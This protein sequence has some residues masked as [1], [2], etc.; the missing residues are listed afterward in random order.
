MGRSAARALFGNLIYFIGIYSGFK[1]V[2]YFLWDKK[3]AD[4]MKE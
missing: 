1:V 4:K 2:D 3:S